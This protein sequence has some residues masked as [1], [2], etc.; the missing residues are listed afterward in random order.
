MLR[1]LSHSQK[2]RGHYDSRNWC[3][4]FSPFHLFHWY[5]LILLWFHVFIDCKFHFILGRVF[6][7]PMTIYL[8]LPIIIWFDITS[9]CCHMRVSLTPCFISH[10]FHTYAIIVDYYFIFDAELDIYLETCSP[11]R[12]RTGAR[13]FRHTLGYDW[14][15]MP[16]FT[17]CI[18]YIFPLTANALFI[19]SFS[20]RLFKLSIFRHY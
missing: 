20:R 5:Y 10:T 18:T 4:R 3:A 19:L 14:D 8:L 15:F 1:F 16:H 6:R 13:W 7:F 12:T 11:E 2:R 9:Y 17:W